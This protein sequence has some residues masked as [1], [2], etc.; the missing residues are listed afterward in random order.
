MLYGSEDVWVG[1]EHVRAYP[2]GFEFRIG[3]RARQDLSP[4]VYAGPGGF[5]RRL[6]VRPDQ[7]PMRG[8]SFGF[9]YSDGRRL[10]NLSPVIDVVAPAPTPLLVQVGGY[11]AGG[12]A[13]RLFWHWGL[14]PAGPLAVVVEL[15]AFDVPE[16][17]VE[18]DG[19][20]LVDAASRAEVLWTDE[21][22]SDR[23]YRPHPFQQR[24]V[25]APEP[26]AGTGPADAD[27]AEREVRPRSRP[28]ATRSMVSW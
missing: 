20:A 10:T 17:R 14:P 6:P 2:D 11:A 23:A 25:F 1:L 3:I 8:L 27:A 22:P 7:P 13:A 21:Q 5:G 16:T 28:C 15:D 12:R 18:L 4:I 19:A 9:G 24:P 26:P